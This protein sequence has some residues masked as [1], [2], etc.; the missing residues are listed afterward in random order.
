MSKHYCFYDKQQLHHRSNLENKLILHLQSHQLMANLIKL[1]MRHIFFAYLRV[2]R[3]IKKLMGNFNTSDC[4]RQGNTDYRPSSHSLLPW[5]PS[6]KQCQLQYLWSLSAN[7]K[8]KRRALDNSCRGHQ[9]EIFKKA[10]FLSSH[11]RH[12]CSFCPWHDESELHTATL[13]QYYKIFR[14]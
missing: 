2:M 9:G 3:F 10:I 1:R 11:L 6:Y 12:I 4:R 5:A 8:L 7:R 13:G 14:Q